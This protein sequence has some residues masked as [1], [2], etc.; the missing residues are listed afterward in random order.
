MT[1]MLLLACLLA[2]PLAPGQEAKPKNPLKHENSFYRYPLHARLAKVKELEKLGQSLGTERLDTLVQEIN[3][4]HI[5]EL[6]SGSLNEVSLVQALRWITED[7]SEVSM[8]IRVSPKLESVKVTASFNKTPVRDVVLSILR[9]YPDVLQW[10][11]EGKVVIVREAVELAPE[12][13]LEVEV[14]PS[15]VEVEASQ[16]RDDA[17]ALSRLRQTAKEGEAAFLRF[18]RSNHTDQAAAEEAM[19]KLMLAVDGLTQLLFGPQGNF[20][21]PNDPEFL[22]G[23]YEGYEVEL[24]HWGQLLHDLAKRTRDAP[25]RKPKRKK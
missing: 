6:V 25:W 14:S 19:T 13:P 11:E 20:V 21:D 22:K 3:S 12:V 1:R 10:E 7:A 17:A 2:A 18:T 23:E 4:Q 24:Q 16:P 15:S 8:V 5:R 9:L